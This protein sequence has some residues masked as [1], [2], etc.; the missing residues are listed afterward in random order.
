MIAKTAR[1][2]IIVVLSWWRLWQWSTRTTLLGPCEDFIAVV[3]D[4]AAVAPKGRTVIL[5]AQ[6]VERASVDA[7]ELGGFGDREEGAVGIIGHWELLNG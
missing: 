2:S 6:V 5:P 1:P 3:D 7:Q 4:A